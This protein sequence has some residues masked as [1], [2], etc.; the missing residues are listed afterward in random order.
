MNAD[1]NG[2]SQ[3]GRTRFVDI[4]LVRFQIPQALCT[5]WEQNFRPVVH[6]QLLKPDCHF[7][8]PITVESDSSYSGIGYIVPGNR[9]VFV[10]TVDPGTT[11]TSV[12][13]CIDTSVYKRTVT[14]VPFTSAP[15]ALH[16]GGVLQYNNA[17]S[18]TCNYGVTFY[19]FFV[20]PT[21]LSDAAMMTERDRLVIR[22]NP[23][24]W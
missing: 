4:G 17:L 2:L 22:P 8:W 23:M 15:Y 10:G 12:R 1:L 11:S 7:V 6:V 9:Y 3:Y 5:V 13:S 20:H 16:L 14:G 21:S 19:E 18:T 24:W